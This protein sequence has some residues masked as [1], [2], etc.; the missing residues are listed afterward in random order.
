MGLFANNRGDRSRQVARD[1]L[2]AAEQLDA[3]YADPLGAIWQR[4]IECDRALQ[5]LDAIILT[6]TPEPVDQETPG[7]REQAALSRP[8]G[9]PTGQAGGCRRPA[10]RRRTSR[11]ASARASPATQCA[12][13]R[14]TRRLPKHCREYRGQ[15]KSKK[16]LA[17]RPPCS[18]SRPV[19]KGS[20][21]RA[22]LILLFVLAEPKHQPSPALERT[23]KK[24][25][26]VAERDLQPTRRG[27]VL[28]RADDRTKSQ[29]ITKGPFKLMQRLERQSRQVPYSDRSE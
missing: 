4:N 12:C 19:T 20:S 13:R 21:R 24:L 3:D 1:H 15:S 28:L 29:P 22:D 16:D 17:E 23:D 18:P 8:P 11:R 9:A 7:R 26:Q 5:P 27:P 2:G 14:A 6:G 10:R 25:P